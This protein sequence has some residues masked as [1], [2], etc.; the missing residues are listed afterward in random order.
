M[1][2]VQIPVGKIGTPYHRP[3]WRY[4]A[5]QNP[6]KYNLDPLCSRQLSTKL[7]EEDYHISNA[8]Y[9]KRLI[10]QGLTCTVIY[11]IPPVVTKFS[12]K[13]KPKLAS[14]FAGL[15]NKQFKKVHPS[16]T[17]CE[18]SDTTANYPSWNITKVKQLTDQYF[19][20][21]ILH[22][23]GIDFSDDIDFALRFWMSPENKEL[24]KH[25]GCSSWAEV[26][27]ETQAKRW[28]I[29]VPRMKAIINLF[30]DFSHFPKDRTARWVMLKQMTDIGELDHG[31]FLFYKK[32]YD[33]GELG[34]K[35]QF[36]YHHLSVEEKEKIATYLNETGITNAININFGVNTTK[37]ILI[38]NRLIHDVH[39]LSIYKQELKQKEAMISLMEMKAKEIGRDINVGSEEANLED[40]KLL[41]A[42]IKELSSIDNEPKFPSIIDV[43]SVP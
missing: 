2:L 38:Y 31:E 16:K 36:D 1:K 22:M 6:Y 12:T 40:V 30:Y 8:G 18:H 29:T 3:S 32:I 15:Y 13:L 41:Q 4:E 27:I 28:R 11:R 21:L 39:K 24:R 5:L 23:A 33:L 37:D 14:K 26:P 20:K 10:N 25:I 42:L 43:Q 17:Y 19:K 35:M 7:G 9:M 34:W